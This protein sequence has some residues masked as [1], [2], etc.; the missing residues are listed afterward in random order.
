MFNTLIL[1]QIFWKK[2]NIFLKNGVSAA[3]FHTKLLCQK[4]MLRQTEW[5][6]Q[7]EPITKDGVLPVTT[8]FFWKFCFSLSTSYKDVLMTNHPNVHILTFRK[9]WSFLR[10]S[11]FPVTLRKK[12]PSTDFF[13]ASHFAVFELNTE[14]YGVNL[15]IQP[16]YRKIWTRKKLLIWTL[17]SQYEYL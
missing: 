13:S 12:C 15:R 4:P 9:L 17:F 16:K 5:A 6:V 2:S 11:F 14:I 7:N 8:L 3:H 1:K 10:G